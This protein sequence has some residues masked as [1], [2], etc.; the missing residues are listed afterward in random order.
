MTAM[1]EEWDRMFEGL[2]AVHAEMHGP[3]G[4]LGAFVAAQF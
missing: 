3:L 4:L 2:R 1:D